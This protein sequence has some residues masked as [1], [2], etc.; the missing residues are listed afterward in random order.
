MSAP[1]ARTVAAP[2]ASHG[3]LDV[4]SLI[5]LAI[6]LS[7]A[8]ILNLT[9]GNALA[10]TGIKPQFIVLAYVLTVQLTRASVAQSVLYGLIAAVFAQLSTSIPGLNLVTEPI[11]AIVLAFAIRADL[12]VAGRDVNP[13]VTAFVT[14]LVSGCLYAVLGTVIMGAAL[15]SALMKAPIVLTTSVFNAIVT[16]ALIAPLR[17]VYKR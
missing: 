1:S 7:A 12:S 2:S 13:L 6:L 9:V 11:S 3:L 17:A 5:L 14:T 15:P 16:Q 8:L 10:M 4:K